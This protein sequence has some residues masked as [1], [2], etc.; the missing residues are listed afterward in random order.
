MSLFRRFGI[1][2]LCGLMSLRVIIMPL[3]YLDYEMNRDYIIKNFC[4]NKDDTITICYGKCYLTKRILAASGDDEQ[5]ARIFA[6]KVLT[7]VFH[8]TGQ[9]KNKPEPTFSILHTELEFAYV[10]KIYQQPASSLIKPPQLQ[11]SA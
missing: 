8:E 3:I 6:F 5:K 2:A 4:V 10:A 1:L 9:L 7:E 11:F